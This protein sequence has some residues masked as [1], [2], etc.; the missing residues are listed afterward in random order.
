MPRA[1]KEKTEKI[2][3]EK[4]EKKVVSITSKTNSK[5]ATEKTNSGKSAESKTTR[6]KR[7]T[8]KSINSKK[9]EKASTKVSSKKALKEE[10]NF[11]KAEE[12]KTTS[13]KK[14]N[15]DTTKKETPKASTTRKSPAKTTRKKGIVESITDKVLNRKKKSHVE[16]KPVRKITSKKTLSTSSTKK[17]PLL[18]EYYD[19][20][21]KYNQTTVKILAQTPTKL[22][23]YW[24]LSDNDRNNYIAN[25]GEDFFNLTKPVL[26]VHNLTMN[27]SFELDINDF[28][29]SWYI[30]VNDPNC[31]YEIELG[32]RP[33]VFNDRIKEPYFHISSSNNLQAPNNHILFENINANTVFKFKNV[34]TQDISIKKL[35]NI[36]FLGNLNKIYNLDD[37]YNLYK[38]FY[39]EDLLKEL[40]ET[41]L[42]NPSSGAIS[43]FK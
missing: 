33:L 9:D 34:K 22:F 36:S 15:K 17:K 6:A 10:E 31:Y 37:F 38:K 12:K 3:D 19:L 23:V 21:Y 41:K 7:S 39:G 27:Y 29:N 24:E 35:S 30:Q 5:R 43:S 13:R 32:R 40:A 14:A 20:P 16:K 1:T 8:T 18:V 25:F 26:I 2:K 4:V 28:A 11:V 42:N